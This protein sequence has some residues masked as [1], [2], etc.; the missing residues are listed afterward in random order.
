MFFNCCFSIS[1]NIVINFR[2]F[3]S[4]RT[5]KFAIPYNEFEGFGELYGIASRTLSKFYNHPQNTPKRP[6]R[7]LLGSLCEPM[8]GPWSSK[9]PTKSPQ[10][11]PQV[12]KRNPEWS[13]IHPQGT[14]RHPRR[15]PRDPQ[16][17]PKRTPSG[18]Q[19]IPPRRPKGCPR[20]L[21]EVLQGS[22]RDP[23][24]VR[25]MFAKDPQG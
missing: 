13:P 2:R 24:G 17:V 6:T 3:Q 15:S 11:P 1:N 4:L 5:S 16:G 12:S 10:E 9:L 18:S 23:Q 14:P 21:Q 20:G 25:K 8:R 19:G 22:P 7:G